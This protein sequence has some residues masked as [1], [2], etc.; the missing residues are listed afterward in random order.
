MN[1]VK[2]NAKCGPKAS[3]LEYRSVL[4]AMRPFTTPTRT[5][6]GQPVGPYSP[7]PDET[8]VSS[9]NMAVDHR[10][11]W[12]SLLDS[13]NVL[14]VVWS[15]NRPIAFAVLMDDE[16][17]EVGWFV[18]PIRY[19][20]TT[21]QHQGKI[22]AALDTRERTRPEPCENAPFVY[23]PKHTLYVFTWDGSHHVHCIANE[24]AETTID[25]YD[26]SKGC[27]TIPLTLE[28]FHGWCDAQVDLYQNND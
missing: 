8:V 27:M 26:Y 17:Q 1:V 7:N 4:D 5:L 21:S 20:A 24:H 22:R 9:G 18:P 12:A 14:Y 28:A 11:E 10:E 23:A 16:T 6:R 13:G 2:L 19:S 15:Y 3:F 25:V